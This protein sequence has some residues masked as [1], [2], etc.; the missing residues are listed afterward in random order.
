MTPIALV[1][2][3]ST[4]GKELKD[5][6]GHVLLPAGSQLT[7]AVLAA[8]EQRG[9]AAVPLA[10]ASCPPIESVPPGADQ[11]R[12]HVDWLFHHAGNEPVVAQLRQLVLDYRLSKIAAP[13]SRGTETE[14]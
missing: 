8:L 12:K 7:A 3:N 14:S 10:P 2:V 5:A 9:I 1:P 4:L 11:L 6:S 13:A